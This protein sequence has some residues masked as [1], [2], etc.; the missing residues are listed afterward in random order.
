MYTTV[1]IHLQYS[2]AWFQFYKLPVHTYTMYFLTYFLKLLFYIYM[3]IQ[4]LYTYRTY[5]IKI[6]FK[7]MMLIT[8]KCNQHQCYSKNVF[9]IYCSNASQLI[10]DHCPLTWSLQSMKWQWQVHRLMALY[11]LCYVYIFHFKKLDVTSH[12]YIW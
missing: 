2:T 9:D 11:L 1:Y 5:K 6:F 12:R 7:I 8:W 3:S 4:V 10:M